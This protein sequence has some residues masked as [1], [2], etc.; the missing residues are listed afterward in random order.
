MSDL[1]KLSVMVPCLITAGCD[2]H[3]REI[4][5]DLKGSGASLHCSDGSG[6]VLQTESLRLKEL[7]QR[8]HGPRQYWHIGLK[9]WVYE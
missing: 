1:R 2:E 4:Y 7:R 8:F 9:R 6:Y 3:L 5:R